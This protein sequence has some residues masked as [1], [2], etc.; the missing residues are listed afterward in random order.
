MANIEQER[1]EQKFRSHINGIAQERATKLKEQLQ[2]AITQAAQEAE[3]RRK[4]KLYRELAK[5]FFAVAGIFGLCM[6]ESAGLISA[7]LT[8]PVYA[9]GFVFIGWHLCK[10]DRLKE[11]K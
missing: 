7:L 8:T 4:R 1:N 2:E 3:N 6:A 5:C 11:R 10:I 9:I